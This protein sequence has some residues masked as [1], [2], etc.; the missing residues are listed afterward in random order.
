LKKLDAAN[1][2]SALVYVGAGDTIFSAAGNQPR[3]GD[4]GLPEA[5][6]ILFCAASDET[7]K[8]LAA[9]GLDGVTRIWSASD[10]KVL[11]TFAPQK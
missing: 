4:Q 7:G 10:R 6:G 8:L 1:E 5:V 3:L 2:V 9:G 11:R